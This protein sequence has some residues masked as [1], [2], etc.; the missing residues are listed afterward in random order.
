M[1]IIRAWLTIFAL[2]LANQGGAETMLID[3]FSANSS[4]KW[5]YFTDRVM[6]GV[7]DGNARI[8][9]TDIG[10]AA[11]MFG[12]VSTANNGG[13]IQIRTG[14]DGKLAQ[15]AEGLRLRVKG[16]G[17]KYYIHLRTSGSFRPW[18]YYYAEFE[19]KSE[20]AEVWLPFK[21]F[22]P[23]ARGMRKSLNPRSIYTLGVVAYGRDHLADLWVDEISFY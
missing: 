12:R 14:L 23:S 16:N 7:S 11:H 5:S 19:T 22:T 9:Q 1:H 3:D 8:V 18:Q 21:N 17:E 2:I 6:G 13:F 15:K 10:P 4:G 20:W